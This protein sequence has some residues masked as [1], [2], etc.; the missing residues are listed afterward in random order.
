MNLH[1]K[2]QADILA[3]IEGL[4]RDSANARWADAEIY[5]A[6]NRALDSWADRVLIPH[7]YTVTNGWVAGTHDYALP[8]YINVRHMQPQ[9]KRTIPYE[10]DSVLFDDDTDEAWQD[11]V[12]W[13][14]EPTATGGH[15]L[16]WQ[17]APW[18]TEGRILWW[19]E[20]GRVPTTATT[21]KTTID[22]DDTTVVC[23]TVVD[24][25]ESGYFKLE[26][27]WMQYAGVTR[28]AADTTLNNVVRAQYGT[29]AAA[30]NSTTALYFGIAAPRSSAFEQLKSQIM[31]NLHALF[32]TNAAPAEREHHTMM[33]RY[34]QQ[35]A[36]LFWRKWT[37]L[38][39]PSLMRLHRQGVGY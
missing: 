13:S 4:M 18:T 32:L 36:D 15:T 29:A 38:K 6:L 3:D 26:G 23:N 5:A 34:Y 2:T 12:A 11:V 37:P 8:A 28:G 25:G 24:V 30:H 19:G 17:L 14:V 16:R 27:E 7:V 35:D 21:L 22:A 10:Y 20:N 33:L 31:A 39:G 9:A 1:L